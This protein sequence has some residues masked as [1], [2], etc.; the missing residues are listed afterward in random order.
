MLRPSPNGK[1]L[2]LHNDDDAI[3]DLHNSHL[4]NISAEE[5]RWERCMH[6]AFPSGET[7]SFYSPIY[8]FHADECKKLTEQNLVINYKFTSRWC[9]NFHKAPLQP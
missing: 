1:I 8:M 6:G 9:Q 4:D 2:W 7:C 5:D 3:V